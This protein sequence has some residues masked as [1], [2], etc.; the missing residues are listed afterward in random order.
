M[1]IE[2]ACYPLVTTFKGFLKHFKL[3]CEWFCKQSLRGTHCMHHSPL[4][5]RPPPSNLHPSTVLIYG[6]IRA[7]THPLFLY[8]SPRC[9][10]QTHTDNYKAS[11]MIVLKAY[12]LSCVG[13]GVFDSVGVGMMDEMYGKQTPPTTVHLFWLSCP[14]SLLDLLAIVT[15]VHFIATVWSFQSTNYTQVMVRQGK[16]D[17]RFYFLQD[18]IS[19]LYLSVQ[20]IK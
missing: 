15:L 1:G 9:R 20:E 7:C 4:S 13:Q 16:I 3:A 11:H 14:S 19:W 10:P 17:Y 8:P 12:N 5:F 2:Q 6:A 18:F